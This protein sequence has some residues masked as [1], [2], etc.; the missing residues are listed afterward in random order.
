MFDTG[1]NSLGSNWPQRTPTL[2]IEWGQI[3]PKVTGGLKNNN[4]IKTSFVAS[5]EWISMG[6][7]HYFVQ[8]IYE[9]IDF[10]I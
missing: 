1:K 3:D 9:L 5:N 4:L 2:N 6:S 8:H 7:F 10:R